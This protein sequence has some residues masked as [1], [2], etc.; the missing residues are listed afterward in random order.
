[1]YLFVGLIIGGMYFQFGNDASKTIFNFGFFFVTN[2]VFMYIPMLPIL[3]NCKYK[4]TYVVII[5]LFSLR[6]ET[7]HFKKFT[8][9]NFYLNLDKIL[10]LSIQ[11]SKW[12]VFSQSE[13]LFVLIFFGDNFSYIFNK[14]YFNGNI[15]IELLKYFLK[16]SL[17][18]QSF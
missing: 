16:F 13:F 2:I 8:E 7:Q 10:S 11:K 4:F 9:K 1:M 18:L 15:T 14:F 6:N 17:L 12:N 5:P 3:L